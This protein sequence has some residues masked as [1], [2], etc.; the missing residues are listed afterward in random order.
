MPV[1]LGV[2]PNHESRA[3]NRETAKPR[4]R[5][6]WLFRVFVFSW[7][8][9]LSLLSAAHLVPATR[10]AVD[11]AN[12][13]WRRG[14]YIAALKGYIQIL[15]GPDADAFVEPIA[16]TTGELFVTHELTSDGRALRFSPDGHFIVYETGLETSR[17][18]RVL[19]NDAART[20]VAELP[21]VS[22]AFKRDGSAVAYFRIT[23]N[24]E[25]RNRLASE[26]LF[27]AYSSFG[28]EPEYQWFEPRGALGGKT[29][30]VVATLRGTVNPELVYIA[31]SH[32]DSVAGGPGAD[33]NS[34]GTAAL[35][36]AARVLASHPQPATI[37]FGRARRA[38]RISSSIDI[39]TRRRRC[40][41]RPV[42][43]RVSSRTSWRTDQLAIH[44]GARS[45]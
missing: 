16:L 33:D 43:S 1:N 24:D 38:S 4:N 27:N 45:G 36:E 7:L 3:R 30:N 25:Y 2:A 23:E 40:R 9:R 20:L 14:D 22:A 15:N 13:A 32:Y 21:G 5:N 18:T 34:S 29:A 10:A 11:T 19:N 26:F 17:R 8:S 12:D 42:R 28:Y 35:L 6:K 44:C 39:R 37:L 41:G 31:S